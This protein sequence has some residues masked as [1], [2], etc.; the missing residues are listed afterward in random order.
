[1]GWWSISETMVNGDGPADHMDK[2]VSKIREEYKEVWGREP[3]TEELE[4][5]LKF[6]VAGDFKSSDESMKRG[7]GINW[8][9]EKG[10]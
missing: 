5:V 9:N 6:C 2:A 10:D 7:P 4:A 8:A 3:Y 1:M